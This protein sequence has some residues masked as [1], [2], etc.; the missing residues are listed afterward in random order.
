MKDACP[1]SIRQVNE[2][3]VRLV[4]FLVFAGAV[5]GCFFHLKWIAAGLAVDF[6]IRAFTPWPVSPLS[7][8]ARSIAGILGLEPRPINAGPKIFAA[9]IGFFF[10]AVIAVLAFM[11]LTT[12]AVSLAG[13]LALF[14]ALES[15]FA[16]CVGC[17]IYSLLNRLRS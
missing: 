5:V 6:F 11:N 15:F 2:T 10:A 7:L 17:H 3:I 16:V 8:M 14:A 1:I 12:V 4:A 9:R 13:V